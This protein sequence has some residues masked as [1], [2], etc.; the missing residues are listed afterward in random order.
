[1]AVD[2]RAGKPAEARDLVDVAALVD[3][4][5]SLRPDPSV[6]AQRVTFGTSGHRGSSLTRTFNEWHVLAISQAICEYRHQAGITGPLYIGIDTHALSV[7]AFR[8]ALEVLAANGVEVLVAANDAFTPTPAISQAILVHNRGRVDALAD[9]IVVTPSHN[10]PEDGGFKYN[11][12]NGGPADKDITDWIGARANALIADALRGVK[13]MPYERAR[14]APTTREHDFVS[15]YIDDLA[16]VIDIDVIR[17]AKLRVGVD[18]LGGAGVHYWGRIAERYRFDLTVVNDAV[19]P[20]FRFMT[21]DW[22]GRIRMDPSSPYAMQR[23]LAIKDRFDIAFACDTD[24]D[25]HG[26]VTP[27]AGLMPPNHYLAASIDYLFRNR[28]QWRS[29]AAVGK[30]IVSSAI[31]DR[32]AKRLGRTLYEVPVGFKWFVDGL[33]GGSIGFAGEESA[34]ATFLRKDGTVWTTD[35]DGIV[36]CLLAA[37]ML[38]KTGRDPATLYRDLT[39]I[40]GAPVNDRVDAA[41]TPAQKARL[42]KLSAAAIPLKELAGEPVQQILDH[43]PANDAPIGGVKV[44]SADGWFAARPSGTENIY[45]VYAES[46]RNDTA[47]KQILADAQKVVD[48]AIA[49]DD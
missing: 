23:M 39:T 16:S 4:Y 18:P 33:L 35:K 49:G 27:A 24:H 22:D 37:E 25:R 42:A 3:A 6:V 2:P 10:P 31:I 32:V 30:T 8:S 28:P 9:G 48:A 1:M 21:L 29:D 12:A 46:F 38:A 45:K 36:P 43:A 26:I 11:P 15:R 34:G 13:R 7:P 5:T 41:A 47:L 14:Q 17:Q 19:D 40:V 20:T 44:V